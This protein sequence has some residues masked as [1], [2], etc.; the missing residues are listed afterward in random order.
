MA[1]HEAVRSL[2]VQGLRCS[3]RIP[4]RVYQALHGRLL[5]AAQR[6]SRGLSKLGQVLREELGGLHLRLLLARLLLVPLPSDVGG[7]LRVLVLRLAGLSIGHG[8]IMVGTPKITGSGNFYKLLKVGRD[9]W[10]NIECVLDVH[11]E[12][13]IGDRVSFGQQV[14]L[15]TNTHEL[16][17]SAWRSGLLKALPVKIGDGAWLGARC[18]ILPGVIVGEGAVVAAGA[19]VT[20]DVSTNTLVAGVPAT[21]VR[22]LS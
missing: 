18:T 13:M 8:T 16:G 5:L 2:W 3:A 6:A 7:R 20:T 22:E 12:V 21:V 11:A 17:P 9:C 14:M 19:M 4:G 15:L 1:Y 10:F